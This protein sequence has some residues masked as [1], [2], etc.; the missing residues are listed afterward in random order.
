MQN[1]TSRIILAC[2]KSKCDSGT[3]FCSLIIFTR[4]AWLRDCAHRR[5]VPRGYTCTKSTLLSS[6]AYLF[7]IAINSNYFIH[8]RRPCNVS[9]LKSHARELPN[10]RSRRNRIW[11]GGNDCGVCPLMISCN[12][13]SCT[14]NADEENR[15]LMLT[16]AAA[17]WM[18]I[19]DAPAYQWVLCSVQR[20]LVM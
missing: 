18:R 3:W 1:R 2:I 6:L 10:L 14:R 7:S 8:F 9:Q 17:E 12:S 19:V 20:R 15:D 5:N 11:V 4:R 13:A 16:N